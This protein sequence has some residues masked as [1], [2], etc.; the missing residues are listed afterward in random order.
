M[1]KF[2]IGDYVKAINIIGNLTHY[3]HGQVVGYDIQNGIQTLQVRYG[4][5]PHDKL[6]VI[7]SNCSLILD[8]ELIDLVKENLSNTI[9]ITEHQLREAF[10]EAL[11]VKDATGW[12]TGELIISKLWR[13][14]G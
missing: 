12:R 8:R 14:N 6:R 3:H 10:A 1:I 9:E 7:S 2:E 4:S 5:R 11:G 13:R